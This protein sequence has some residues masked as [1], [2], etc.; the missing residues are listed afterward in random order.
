MSEPRSVTDLKVYALKLI[1]E[2]DKRIEL[3]NEELAKLR[4]ELEKIMEE[5]RAL[6]KI[7][8][9]IDEVEN[10]LAKPLVAEPKKAV[11]ENGELQAISTAAKAELQIDAGPQLAQRPS[12]TAEPPISVR[13]GSAQPSNTLRPVAR[14]QIAVTVTEDWGAQK[15]SAAP[16]TQ[17]S[18]RINPTG[19]AE[20]PSMDLPPKSVNGDRKREV[21]SVNNIDYAYYSL[22]KSSLDI[23]FSFAVPLDSK[24]IKGFIIDKYLLNL[25]EASAQHASKEASA[26]TF[27]YEVVTS[28]SG[29][30]NGIRIRNFSQEQTQDIVNKIKWFV[31]SEVRDL[32]S[33]GKIA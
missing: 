20:K 33:K 29:E 22:G 26:G 11:S 13:S 25:K 31:A 18:P 4:K 17:A 21:I 16:A 15:P 19:P 28:A 3:K 9:E 7:V 10:G 6:S 1:T 23:D 5:K 32:K 24:Y 12:P 14:S 8:S 2:L 30:I 27:S